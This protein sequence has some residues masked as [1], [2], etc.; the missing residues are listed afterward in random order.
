MVAVRPPNRSLKRGKILDS[1]SAQD[2]HRH[3]KLALKNAEGMRLAARCERSERAGARDRLDN[4]PRPEL[5]A[6]MRSPEYRTFRL[7]IRFLADQ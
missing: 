3:K 4:S 2:E 6:A 1:Q 7:E 5:R